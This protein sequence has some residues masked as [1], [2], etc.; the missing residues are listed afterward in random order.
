MAEES[1]HTFDK[2]PIGVGPNP[3]ADG[4]QRHTERGCEC[5]WCFC[6]WL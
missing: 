6:A 3:G 2:V 1:R 4:T 5:E